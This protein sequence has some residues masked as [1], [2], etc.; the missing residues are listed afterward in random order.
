VLDNSRR[1]VFTQQDVPAPAQK[2][3]ISVSSESPHDAVRPAAIRAL[4]AMPDEQ[5]A[6]FTALA[7]LI[8]KDDLVLPAAQGISVLPRTAWSPEAALAAAPALVAWAKKV[9]AAERTSEDYVGAVQIASDLA[10]LLP[11]DKAA[12]L[13]QD[14]RELR[15]AVFVVRAVREQMRFDTPRIVVEAGKPFEIIVENADFMPHNLVVM[16]P[17]AREKLGPIAEVMLPDQLDAKGRPY[18]PRSPDVLAATRLLEAGQKETLKLTAPTAE[19]SYEFVCTF[20]GHWQVMYGQLVVTGDVD[21][22]LQKHPE[23]PAQPKAAPHAHDH[24]RFE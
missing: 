7:G 2:V 8:A 20:P 17:G 21:A 18:I 13:R 4:V 1:P 3:A 23:A 14:L 10:G 15:V 5:Q 22:Y 9:P 16:N 19:G 6:T 11:G 12:A 24:G